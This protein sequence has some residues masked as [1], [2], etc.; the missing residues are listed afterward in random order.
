M[1]DAECTLAYVVDSYASLG[2][3]HRTLCTFCRL[4]LR[5]G[6]RSQRAGLVNIS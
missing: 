3:A 5:W 4:R 2:G 1:L 6:G